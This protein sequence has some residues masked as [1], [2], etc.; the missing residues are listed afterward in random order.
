MQS[1]EDDDPLSSSYS[2]NDLDESQLF[3]GDYDTFIRKQSRLLKIFNDE[4]REKRKNAEN[5]KRSTD[6]TK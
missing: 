4:E 5:Q 2:L 1:Q 3:D 6:E